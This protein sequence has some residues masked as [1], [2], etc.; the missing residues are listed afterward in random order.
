MC[1]KRGAMMS[2]RR[3]P[4]LSSFDEIH[5]H[6]RFANLASYQKARRNSQHMYFLT[7]TLG[8]AQQPLQ[9]YSVAIRVTPYN[10]QAKDV[11]KS[12]R[13]YFGP[14]WG[15]RMFEG[16]RGIDGRFG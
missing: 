2:S 1:S 16:T 6:D 7:H 12:A 4:L 14:S 8:P 11:V 15:D 5:G 9:K 10:N 3:F 13:F